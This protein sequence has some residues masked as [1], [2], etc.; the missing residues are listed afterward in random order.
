MLLGTPQL[1]KPAKKMTIYKH[2]N[3][4]KRFQEKFKWRENEHKFFSEL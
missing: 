3:I 1:I 4:N 2:F